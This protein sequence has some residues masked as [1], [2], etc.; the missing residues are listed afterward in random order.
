MKKI[1]ILI[2]LLMAIYV[3]DAQIPSTFILHSNQYDMGGV[4]A[5]F[6]NSI[7]T[8]EEDSVKGFINTA[9]VLA[10]IRFKY[11]QLYFGEKFGFMF[12]PPFIITPHVYAGPY[13]SFSAALDIQFMLLL[14]PQIIYNDANCGFQIIYDW[15]DV[16]IGATAGISSYSFHGEQYQKE[17]IITVFSSYRM[18]FD[19]TDAVLSS[20]FDLLSK[21]ISVNVM[22]QIIDNDWDNRLFD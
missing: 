17:K 18:H 2:I 9:P 4:F 1:W 6:S 22:I 20:G 21:D 5:G 16:R 19:E 3:I 11:V 12:A 8:S 7:N 15:D 14:F 10:G 13:L